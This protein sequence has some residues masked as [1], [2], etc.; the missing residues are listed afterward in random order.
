MKDKKY[1][2]VVQDLLPNYIENLT[3]EETNLFIEEHLKECSE[4]NQIYENMKAQLSGEEGKANK[5]EVNY[6]K[7][8]NNKLRI[9][10]SII[11]I[12][13]IVFPTLFCYSS[14]KLAI[15]CN[16][17]AKQADY[18]NI[19]NF[20]QRVI[21]NTDEV[22]MIVDYYKKGNKDVCYQIITINETG[23]TAKKIMFVDESETKMYYEKGKENILN[24]YD[25]GFGIMPVS[26]YFDFD[27]IWQ[28]F[29]GMQKISVKEVQ[30]NGKACYIIKNKDAFNLGEVYKDKQTGL[31]LKW[32]DTE[33]EYEFDNV[34]DDVF[35]EPD[36]NEYE[37]QESN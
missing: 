11:I 26:M 34:K 20:H 9:L 13:L 8:F 36:L 25:L 16:L 1:C 31:T 18:K 28:T 17:S 24:E 3:N 6:L 35:D 14:R 2:K 30:I 19:Q 21:K 22:N 5:K 4:C 32:K 37:L 15:L 27:G 23:E 7:K 10:G 33:Y 12:L 29:I